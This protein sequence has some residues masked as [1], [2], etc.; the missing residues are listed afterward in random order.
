VPEY[1]ECPYLGGEVELTD[2]RR[3]H[4]RRE[5]GGLADETLGRLRAAIRDPDTVLSRRRDPSE[6][7]LARQEPGGVPGITVVIIASES[8]VRTSEMRHSS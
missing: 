8:R 3:Q 5:R 4:I 1:F 2:E 7:L 6:R